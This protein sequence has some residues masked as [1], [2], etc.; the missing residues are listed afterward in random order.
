MSAAWPGLS[1]GIAVV[2]V[3]GEALVSRSEAAHKVAT[4]ARFRDRR[5]DAS[6]ARQGTW[7]GVND[8][9]GRTHAPPHH[10]LARDIAKQAAGEADIG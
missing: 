6:P 5:R 4:A 8:S 1:A 3:E 9:T 7:S 10:R 2:G